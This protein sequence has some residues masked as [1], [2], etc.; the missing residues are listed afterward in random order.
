MQGHAEG[1]N[2]TH[3]MARLLQCNTIIA[4]AFNTVP[5]AF[6][7]AISWHADSLRIVHKAKL[8]SAANDLAA[9]QQQHWIQHSPDTR[10]NCISTAQN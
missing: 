2:V 9:A 10:E 7:K 4:S 3:S 1:A 8:P 5:T 6:C